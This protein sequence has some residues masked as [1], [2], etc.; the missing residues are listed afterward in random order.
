MLSD[1]NNYLTRPRKFEANSLLDLINHLNLVDLKHI[2]QCRLH[3]LGVFIGMRKNT[4]I[5][6]EISDVF[7]NGNSLQINLESCGYDSIYHS[8]VFQPLHPDLKTAE[9]VKLAEASANTAEDIVD[10]PGDTE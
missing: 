4:C 5:T 1:E 6:A 8:S 7:L 9:I 10:T 2:L 3:D